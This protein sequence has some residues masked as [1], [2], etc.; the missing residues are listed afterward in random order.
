MARRID[1]PRGILLAAPVRLFLF[2]IPLLF[3]GSCKDE[4]KKD[5]IPEPQP[6]KKVSYSTEI[7][8]LLI[9][10][11]TSCHGD[12]PLHDPKSW[13]LLHQHED[14]NIAGPLPLIQKWVDEGREVDPH[15]AGQPLRNVS[16]SSVDDFVSTPTNPVDVV[17]KRPPIM[18]ST[19]VPN[20]LAGDLMPEEGRAVSTG[21]LR[22]GDDTP[23]WRV[24]K[25]AREFLGTRITCAKCHDHPSEYWSNNRYQCLAE[26]FTTPYDSIPNALPP[27]YV[28][29][30]PDIKKQI[31]KLE[32]EISEAAKAPPV[33]EEDY[34]SW[35]ALDE[36]LPTLPGLIAAY[37]FEDRQ[38]TN[39][40][41]T[42]RVIADGR[43]L[44]A[45]AGAH[46]MGLQFNGAN[47]LL[48]SKLPFGNEL[49]RFTISVWIKLTP[50]SLADTSIATIGL[51]NRGFELRVLRG[52]L[53]A[54]WSQTW[55][56]HAIATTSETPLIAPNRWSHVAVTY[57]GSRSA[58]GMKLYLN[59]RP[60]DS[61]TSPTK[62]LKTV[63]LQGDTM[64]FSGP[65]LNIDELQVYRDA[66]TPIG[67]RQTFDGKSLV[68]AYQNGGDLREFYQRHYG[69]GEDSRRAKVR[70]LIKELLAI[71]DE[72]DV[73]LAMAS[74]PH[75]QLPEGSTEPA[76]RLEFA[77]RLNPDLLARSLANEIW[78][79]HF[80]TP[81]AHS[82]GFSDPLPSHPDLLEWLAGQLKSLDF[83]VTRLG[84][85]IQDSQT[86]KREWP[87]LEGAPAECPREEG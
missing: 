5:P 33:V 24:E 4:L 23:E 53:Q 44:V 66:L 51:K 82:L 22:Q 71:E 75:H 1:L 47:Q 76:N 42:G 69:Q 65:G 49:D 56:Q 60:V 38:L 78:R 7:R 31:S 62:L 80:G 8:P 26:L 86:W 14:A 52:K 85:L 20:L 59:G 63:L 39:L 68:E 81:L 50:A 10:N 48:L 6:E 32:K 70:D 45:E 21:Y 41:T 55:P 74:N 9:R 40:A 54:R 28:S 64:T 73:F 17:R 77:Q 84:A 67:I 87:V 43:D 79:N 18:F 61:S 34:L 16:G 46:G 29:V 35:L 58:E 11:C 57:D 15:W 27:L 3:L 30:P 72:L 2:S 37:S 36:S 13:D 25:I 83:N 19:S 12:L